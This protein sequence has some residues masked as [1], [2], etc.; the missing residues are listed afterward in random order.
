MKSI[1]KKKSKKKDCVHKTRRS[2]GM[3][4]IFQ[5]KSD[6]RWVGSATIGHDE[7]GKQIKRSVY[8]KTQK[9]VTIK[10][11]ELTG[12]M[13][14][15][16]EDANKVLFVDLMKD[17]LLRFKQSAM[18]PR[19]FEGVMTNYNLHILPAYKD[20]LIKDV[21]YVVVQK[22]IN[23]LIDKG[24]SVSTI[25]SIK[26]LIGQFFEF[27][28]EQGLVEN[29][30]TSR[31]KISIKGQTDYASK[32]KALN[33]E[34]RKKLLEALDNDFEYS[35]IKP[36]CYMMMFAGLRAGEALALK[37]SDI[38]FYDKSI[39][40]GSAIT[41]IPTFD[42]DGKIIKRKSV[43]S[44][45]KTIC[46][47]RTIPLSEILCNELKTWHRYQEEKNADLVSLEKPVFCNDD[48]S[49]RTYS[50]YR[51]IFNR[52][53]RRQKLKDID[54]HFHALR[55]TFSN[56]LL[57]NK[58]NPKI[59]Q[60]LLGHRNVKTTITVYN[61]VN[62]EYVKNAIKRF[63]V[64]IDKTY[65]PFIKT[66]QK[67]QGMIEKDNQTLS[68]VACLSNEDLNDLFAELLKEKYRRQIN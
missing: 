45:T 44:D 1:I 23:E 58:V 20:L 12:R 37:W 13:S 9:E 52:F 17:W 5:R 10:L 47:R 2:N 55:H 21:D 53:L 28:I 32:F 34:N 11:C 27:A 4:S 57:E 61:S 18:Q 8:G 64:Q 50:G 48:G 39:R 63:N 51:N 40:V 35:F 41:Q 14:D 33:F 38:D 62:D 3:G 6:G 66:R 65:S 25:K 42:R 68:S 19:S 36:L 59:V 7:N 16:L 54:F 43:L 30:P 31:I 46:S 67:Q 60:Q 24:Y 22:Q 29:N 15:I 26:Q 56:M 49:Y